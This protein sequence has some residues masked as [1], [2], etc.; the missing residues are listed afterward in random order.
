MQELFDSIT[1]LWLMSTHGRYFSQFKLVPLVTQFARLHLKINSTEV[2]NE[3]LFIDCDLVINWLVKVVSGGGLGGFSLHCQV[4][5][6]SS[7]QGNSIIT[8]TGKINNY[9]KYAF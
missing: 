3:S 5:T 7:Q 8:V 6:L 4:S 2:C 1:M 9:E